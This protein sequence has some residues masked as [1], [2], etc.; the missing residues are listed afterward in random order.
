MSVTEFFN[1]CNMYPWAYVA[2]LFN[3]GVVFMNGWTDVP[4]CIATCVTT[5]CMKPN[6]AIYMAAVGNLLGT[7]A[8][9]FLASILP[10]GDV[11]K[12]VS[13][14]V[15]FSGATGVTL[16]QMFIAIAF[17]LLANVILSLICTKFGFPSSQSNALV[18][19]LTGSGFAIALFA[20]KPMFALIGGAAWV[21]VLIGFFGS[22][23]FGFVLGWLFSWMIVLI[24]RPFKRGAVSRFFSKGQIVASGIMSLAHGLQDGAK[25][26]GVFIVIAVMLKAGGPASDPALFDQMTGMWW[27]VWP[28]A[29]VIFSGT[30]MGGKSIIKTMG[31]GMA[32]LHKYQGFATD[33][34]AG[35]GLILATVFGLPISSGTIKATSIMGVGAQRNPR[36]VNWLKA[37]QMVLSWIAIF[38]GTAIIGF[39]L[40]A[41]FA[42]IFK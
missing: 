36:R 1:L 11:S 14:I 10:L 25:F 38:P 6:W 31:S 28:V 41:G 16:N 40:T 7:L 15:D 35:L 42:A 4:N 30:L 20:N 13:S 26:L 27:I 34:A 29:I 32:K 37:G 5:R 3:L 21:K 22:I 24:C 19:G 18:G 33:I 23:V 2:I 9:G 39:V 12:T 8:A 17:G